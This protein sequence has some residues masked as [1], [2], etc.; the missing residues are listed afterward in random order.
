MSQSFAVGDSVAYLDKVIG[1]AMTCSVVRVMPA[2]R[3]GRYYHIRSASELFDRS[4]PDHTLTRLGA[5][6][7]DETFGPAIGPSGP[8]S[9]QH[10]R[11]RTTRTRSASMQRSV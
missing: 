11:N 10:S 4:V 5:T 1:Q 7:A 6:L 3:Y 8:R 2:E 9:P